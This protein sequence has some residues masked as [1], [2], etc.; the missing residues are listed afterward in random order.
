MLSSMHGIVVSAV[1]STAAISSAHCRECTAARYALISS[2]ISRSVGTWQK[3]EFRD[4]L[5]YPGWWKV[6][7]V[8]D[9]LVLM[10]LDERNYTGQ[11]DPPYLPKYSFPIDRIVAAA[12]SWQCVG[13]S[14]SDP[15][16]RIRYDV[17]WQFDEECNVTV[18]IG[19]YIAAAFLDPNAEF[20]LFDTSDLRLVCWK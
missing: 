12:G 15:S 14:D 3:E 18:R 19:V 13:F 10:V 6:A 1:I 16:Y 2:A 11:N 8:Q 20:A 5:H 9:S 7:M 17:L 4:S